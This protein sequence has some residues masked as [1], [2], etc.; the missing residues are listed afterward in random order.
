M[1]TTAAERLWGPAAVP[2]FP[3][4]LL[5]VGDLPPTADADFARFLGAPLPTER[6][7]TGRSGVEAALRAATDSGRGTEGVLIAVVD[8]AQDR[9]GPA[10][11]RPVVRSDAGVAL[12]V[13][14]T[15]RTDAPTALEPSTDDGAGATPALFRL[16]RSLRS[17]RPQDWL[18]DWDIPLETS[19]PAATPLPARPELPSEGPL[20]QGAYVPRPRYVENLP[21]RWRLLAERCRSCGA[22]TF[23]IRGR[24]RQCGRTDALGVIRLPTDGGEVVATTTIG[25][26]GQPTEFDEQV[27][28]SGPYGVVLV[29]LLPGVRLTL[30]VADGATLAIGSRV[31]TRLRRLYPMEGAWRYGRKAVPLGVG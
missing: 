30:Q 28:S 7:R 29:E 20:S 9:S 11:A 24:C 16:G 6:C 12:W 10:E 21:S 27:A 1:A 26:G 17:S 15:D 13:G 25:P 4:R 3:A 22:V 31:A 18:G 2:P 19:T 23:P 8:L 5:L 14:E